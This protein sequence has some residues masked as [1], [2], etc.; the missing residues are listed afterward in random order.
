MIKDIHEFLT[1][2]LHRNPTQVYKDDEFLEFVDV[3]NRS[4]AHILSVNLQCNENDVDVSI[5]LNRK[6]A[7]ATNMLVYVTVANVNDAVKRNEIANHVNNAVTIIASKF[8][9]YSER[10]AIRV[11]SFVFRHSESDRNSV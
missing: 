7:T 8:Q 6:A 1:E 4:I 10:S 11:K 5:M 9:R 2:A 3:M